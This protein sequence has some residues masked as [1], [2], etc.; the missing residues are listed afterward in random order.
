MRIGKIFL[1]LFVVL[2]SVTARGESLSSLV[3]KL[4]SDIRAKKSTA[5]I[6]EDVKKVLSAKEHLPVN[7][8]PE[9]NYLLKKEV[10]KVPSTSLSGVKK[11]LYY[12]GLLSKTVYSVLF[13]LVFYTFLFYFQQVEG[14]GRKRLLLT[15]GALS[16]PVISLFSGNLSLFIFSASLSVL[17]NVKMEKKRTAIFSSLFILF[18]F[19]YHAFEENA[20]SYLKNPKTLYSLKVERDGYVPEYLIEEAV[21][22]S[23][24]RKIE[25]ASNLLA[26]GDFKAVEALKK[27]EG[28]VTD[29]KLRA[30]VLNN[31]GYYYFMKAKYK[32][33]EK[34]F[35]NSIK[36]DPSP[37]AKYNLYLAYSA[38]LKV[39]EATKL[40]NELE[41][42]DFFFLKATPLVVH[43]PVSSFSYYFPL[44]ELLALLVGLA[45]GFGVIHFLHLRLGSYEPQ[46]LRIPGIIGYI[47]GNFVF[48][49]AVFLLVLLSNYLLGRAVC[50]I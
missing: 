10:E 35:L 18:L 38:L 27:L 15:L 47:N 22:G 45:V 2:F 34:Y 29:P 17:L 20:L 9:L 25:K 7:Y 50:S 40:K 26:L 36:L 28:T 49:I 37:F 6:E 16:L 44:K 39:N 14:S 11:S 4:E 41:K 21:D 48:F 33:A 12:L 32:R 1:A 24:A 46:L 43:V 3:Q 5:V 19:L 42:D 23:L 31:L 8:V 30:I 13:L